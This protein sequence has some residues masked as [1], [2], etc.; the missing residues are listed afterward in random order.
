MP[1]ALQIEDELNRVTSERGGT[2]FG[3]YQLDDG[4]RRERYGVVNT[5]NRAR[6]L[7]ESQLSDMYAAGQ[8]RLRIL[9]FHRHGPDSGTIMDS[10]SGALSDVNQQN[11]ADLLSSI[12]RAGFEGVQVGFFPSKDN[13]ALRWTEWRADLY[14]ENRDLVF[15]TR[16]VLV[17]SGVDY[18]ID[19]CNEL[20]PPAGRPHQLRAAQ[21]LWADYTEAFGADDTIGFSCISDEVRVR[22]LPEVYRG[23]LPKAVDLHIYPSPGRDEYQRFVRAHQVLL[24]LGLGDLPWIIGECH[25]NDEV[26][27]TNL[28]R[29]ILETNQSVLHLLQWQLTRA[30]ACAD[31][32]TLA[33]GYDRYR[34]Q[35]F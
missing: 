30:K 33:V 16:P 9:I 14:R 25:Y 32:D 12:D 8:R 21:Q 17:D 31:V 29:A 3:W 26:A 11:L 24:E 10:S 22:M 20:V 27:A 15:R 34:A 35:G 5:F 19:L 2:N 4:C 18:T 28:R 23:A 1:I 7:I 13:A 6:D